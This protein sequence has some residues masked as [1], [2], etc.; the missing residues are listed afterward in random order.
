VPNGQTVVFSAHGVSPAVRERAKARD[1]RMIDA[2]CPLVTK[3]HVEARRYAKQGCKILLIG[4]AGHDEVE[5]TFGEAPDAITIVESPEDVQATHF[6]D[7]EQLVYLTQ[8]TLSIDDA[9]VIIEAI[10]QKYPHCKA[11]PKEDICYATTN[12]Q[13]AVRDLAK[14]ADLTLVVGS[15]NSSNSVRLTEISETDGTKAKLLD[16]KSE[17]RADWFEGVET[18]LVTAGASAP[19]DLVQEILDELCEN[20]GGEVEESI[21]VDEGMQFALPVTLRVLKSEMAQ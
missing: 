7:D 15:T 19:D 6:S 14:S 3:V 4:H 2:T 10:K 21:P 5:G 17:L 20:H 8:T 13:N 9:N 1:L 11:P 18:V 12:R 16:D